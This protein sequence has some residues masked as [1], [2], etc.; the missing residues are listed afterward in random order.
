MAKKFMIDYLGTCTITAKNEKEA[1]E[2]FLA[3]VNKQ[4]STKS[5]NF[6]EFI[7]DGIIEDEE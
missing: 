3:W 6:D 4:V 2:K 7:I 1:K 5:F